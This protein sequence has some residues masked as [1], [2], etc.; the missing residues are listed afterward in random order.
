MD[1]DIITQK[2]HNVTQNRIVICSTVPTT[3]CCSCSLK[4]EIFSANVKL[5]HLYLDVNEPLMSFLCYS[6][7]AY[8]HMRF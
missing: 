4:I 5:S 1:E 2:K 3:N 8:L 7:S 6:F